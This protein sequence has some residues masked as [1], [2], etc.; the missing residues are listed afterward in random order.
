MGT[1]G[2]TQRLPKQRNVG[3]NFRTGGHGRPP[4][5]TDPG[6]ERKIR[7]VII[8]PAAAARYQAANADGRRLRTFASRQLR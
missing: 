6:S 8:V 7:A 1:A 2:A 5:A 3:E 4:C